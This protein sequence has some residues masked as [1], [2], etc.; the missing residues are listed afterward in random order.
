MTIHFFSFNNYFI[1]F[2]F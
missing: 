1:G 2:F